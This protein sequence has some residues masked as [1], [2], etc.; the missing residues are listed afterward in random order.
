MPCHSDEQR[1]IMPEISRPPILGASHEIE[2]FL[3]EYLQ[4]N[5]LEFLCIVESLLHGV[6]KGRMLTKNVQF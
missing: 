1:T 6:G 2:Y 3:F 4:I 5:A